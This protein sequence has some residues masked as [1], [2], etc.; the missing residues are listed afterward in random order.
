MRLP[1]P[2]TMKGGV[3]PTARNARTGELT[4]PGM[5]FCARANNASFLLMGS[6]C[7][8]A[9]EAARGRLD[10]GRIEQ[11]ADYRDRIGPCLDDLVSVFGRNAS[12]R[13]DRE[14][15]TRPRLA[16]EGKRSTRR[17]RLA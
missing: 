11:R 13:D 12:D 10:V 5:V 2:R 16:I 8:K 14:I 3:P 1:L 7:R 17:F 15:Q 4:P 9:A 6:S